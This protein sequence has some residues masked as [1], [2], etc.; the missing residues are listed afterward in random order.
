[1]IDNFSALARLGGM[2]HFPSDPYKM[3]AANRD[4]EEE[5]LGWVVRLSSGEVTAEERKEFGSWSEDRDNALAY[6][7]AT[8][9]WAGLGPILEEQEEAGWPNA[10]SPGV[11]AL[12]PAPEPLPA[13]AGVSRSPS[14]WRIAGIAASLALAILP[15]VQYV[16][17]W[18]YDHVSGSSVQAGLALPDGSKIAM[19]P[20]TAISTDFNNGARHVSLARGEVYFDV[21]HDPAHPFVVSSGDGVV[22]VLGTAFTVRRRD[23]DSVI[24]T[25]T[26]G[27]V[28]VTSGA[29]TE[30]LTPDRQISFDYRGLGA[31]RAVDAS[32]AT[33]WMRGRLIM[34]NRPLGEVLSELD[35]YDS[36]KIVLLNSEAAQRRINAVIDLERTD[37]WLSALASSQGLTLTRIGPLKILR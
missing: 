23:D 27:R 11:P 33:A 8:R 6:E 4:L 36:G 29:R 12:L 24:V 34:E 30:V 15:A 1:M 31:L 20:D 7:R 19:G 37:G 32:V 3:G 14:R 10:V 28:Q 17:V 22:R 25:V 21:R 35:R 5:A 26:R 16:R 18:Q 2:S 9:L 13:V